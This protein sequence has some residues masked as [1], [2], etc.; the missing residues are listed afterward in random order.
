METFQDL[1]GKTIAKITGGEVES[2]EITFYMTDGS[3][4]RL[5][6]EQDCCEYVRVSDIEGDLAELIND[7]ILLAE[8]VSSYGLPEPSDATDLSH[9]WTF[10]KL[11]TVKAS[12]TIRWLGESNGYYSE[13]VSFCQLNKSNIKK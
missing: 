2:E 7:P 1:E 5:Y 9:T 10:Y 3:I 4:Y 13:E 8:E 11:S 12:V 6:H